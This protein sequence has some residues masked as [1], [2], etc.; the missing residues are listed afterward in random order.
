MKTNR[1]PAVQQSVNGPTCPVGG[2]VPVLVVVCEAGE[3]RHGA[4]VIVSDPLDHLPHFLPPLLLFQNPCL[5]V[6]GPALPEKTKTLHFISWSSSG[7][8][9]GALLF[10]TYFLCWT[11]AVL[12]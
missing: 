8:C 7:F 3:S 2:S 9:F 1:N 11:R 4:G 12:V 10:S 5:F 6:T